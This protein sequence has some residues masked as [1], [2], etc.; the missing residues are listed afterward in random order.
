MYKRGEKKER[1]LDFRCIHFFPSSTNLS[2]FL[3]MLTGSIFTLTSKATQQVLKRNMLSV[4]NVK[5]SDEYWPNM[6]SC[7]SVFKCSHFWPCEFKKIEKHI[8][9][10]RSTALPLFYSPLRH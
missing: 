9:S 5:L 1:P 4:K 8:V 6:I 7:F 10:S 3:S 2:A